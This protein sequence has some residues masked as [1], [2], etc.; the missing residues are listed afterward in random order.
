VHF[1]AEPASF[2]AGTM[3]KD[4]ASRVEP[5]RKPVPKM[6]WKESPQ[7]G[8]GLSYKPFSPNSELI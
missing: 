4:A 7:G 3:R 8:P 5:G 1:Q 2:L 6:V